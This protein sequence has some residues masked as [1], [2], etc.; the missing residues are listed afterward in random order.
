MFEESE[1]VFWFKLLSARGVQIT[2]SFVAHWLLNRPIARLDGLG[3]RT[4]HQREGS[5]HPPCFCLVLIQP[6]LVFLQK[7]YESFM[8]Y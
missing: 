8:F 5:L 7:L 1:D 4:P 6:A 3:A 2:C